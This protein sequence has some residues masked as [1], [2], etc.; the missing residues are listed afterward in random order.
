MHAVDVSLGAELLRPEDGAPITGQRGEWVIV[1]SALADDLTMYCL[2]H[3]YCTDLEA[4]GVLINVARYL[5]GHGSIEL[6]ARIYT[7]M[8]DD[9]LDSISGKLGATLN[10]QKYAE[11]RISVAK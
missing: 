10:P 2:R 6:T 7:H 4:A 3:T 5:M 8:R 11:T 9:I 1:R